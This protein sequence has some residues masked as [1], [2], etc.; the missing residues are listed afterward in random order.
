MIRRPPRSTLSSSSAAS[1]VYK[2]QGLVE[3]STRGTAWLAGGSPA[4]ATATVD[5]PLCQLVVTQTQIISSA[6][7]GE[8]SVQVAP[9][10]GP[11]RK[12]DRCGAAT[13][14]ST[15]SPPRTRRGARG[16]CRRGRPCRRQ[17]P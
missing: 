7:T 11:G 9:G 16:S 4:A 8:G 12:K 10:A 2:R 1:D 5:A 6:P 17:Y 14:C 3:G 13:N 15:S